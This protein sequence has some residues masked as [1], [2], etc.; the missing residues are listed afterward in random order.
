MAVR[1]YEQYLMALENDREFQKGYM[2]P[3]EINVSRKKTI[4]LEADEGITPCTP[5][6][7]AP[8]KPVI[9]GGCISFGAQTHPADGNAGLI[10]TSKAK[11]NKLSQDPDVTIQLLSYGQARA[12]KAHMAAS[13]TPAA[14]TALAQAGISVKDLAAVKTHNPLYGERHRHGPPDEYSG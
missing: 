2:L 6:G 3:V 11:A 10:I 14:E 4:T 12:K 8:L 9:P 7:L 5:E 1:R 13:V